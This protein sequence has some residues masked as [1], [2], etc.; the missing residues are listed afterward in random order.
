G[1]LVDLIDLVGGGRLAMGLGAVV[2][3]GLAAGFARVRLGLV[4]G[5]GS[6]LSLGCAGGLVELAAEAVVL[7]L[8]VAEASLQ[9][10]AAGTRDGLHTPIIGEAPAT[11]AL[12]RPRRRR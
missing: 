4:L 7:G 1:R 12:P 8:Q 5:E 2:L 9:G 11:L 3:A 6:G 10:S